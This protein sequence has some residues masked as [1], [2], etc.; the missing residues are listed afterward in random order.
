MKTLFILL[1]LCPFISRAQDSVFAALR[2]D[3]LVILHSV[4]PIETL[5]Q[6]ARQYGVPMSELRPVYTAADSSQTGLP[7]GVEIPLR[8]QLVG[9]TAANGIPVYFRCTGMEDR[10]RLP[11]LLGR[12]PGSLQTAG[13]SGCERGQILLLGYL[14]APE[15][16]T[17]SGTGIDSVRR[18]KPDSAWTDA[19]TAARRFENQQSGI[20]SLLQQTGPVAF[21]SSAAPPGIY[22][23]L[24]PTAA[25][26]SWLRVR[27]PVNGRVIYAKVLGSLPRTKAYA[28]AVVAVS[29]QARPVLGSLGDARLWCEITYLSGVENPSAPILR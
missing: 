27:N 18:E 3:Q 14:R 1:A 6:L 13:P 5:P 16:A 22:Y 26:G 20:S 9:A 2:R 7:A 29:Q 8:R 25:R 21:F 19:E 28:R 24:H 4:Q 23:A 17:D 12:I 10:Y 11:E 15:A